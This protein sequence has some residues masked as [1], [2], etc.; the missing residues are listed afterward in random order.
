M[1]IT[2]GNVLPDGKPGVTLRVYRYANQRVD[3]W[4]REYTVDLVSW[5]RAALHV[6]TLAL[7][8]CFHELRARPL[9][10]AATS[11]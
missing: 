2:C 4:E 8:A 10:A 7:E 3:D 11:A 5:Q 1:R 6:D 9:D